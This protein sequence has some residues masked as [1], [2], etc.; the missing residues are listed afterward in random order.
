MR[1]GG[2]D[3]IRPW[4]NE[5]MKLYGN[6]DTRPWTYEVSASAVVAGTCCDLLILFCFGFG[7]IHGPAEIITNS[8]LEPSRSHIWSSCSSMLES[9]PSFQDHIGIMLVIMLWSIWNCCNPIRPT[10]IRSDAQRP[11]HERKENKNARTD[12][13][14]NEW[15]A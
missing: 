11:T 12:C 3:A 15:P 8:C 9:R 7:A 4:G 2:C 13:N 6:E 1:G 10:P 14:K 5:T